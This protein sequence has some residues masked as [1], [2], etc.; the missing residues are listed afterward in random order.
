[1][2]VLFGDV[3][4]SGFREEGRRDSLWVKH[5]HTRT[6]HALFNHV[7]SRFSGL[8][9]ALQ[10]GVCD[11]LRQTL[12]PSELKVSDPS[13]TEL[14][15][16]S[17][18]SESSNISLVVLDNDENLLKTVYSSG[19]ANNFDRGIA[20]F[21]IYGETVPHYWIVQALQKVSRKQTWT[22]NLDTH[23]SA[24]LQSHKT[25]TEP[26]LYSGATWWEK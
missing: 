24:W 18:R 17:C 15:H 11:W 6:K 1:M 19:L 26:G 14:I 25:S 9:L 20:L 10:K 7:N 12:N 13:K 22:S 23:S 2:P 16:T 3:Q 21:V 8:S 5:T 4:T